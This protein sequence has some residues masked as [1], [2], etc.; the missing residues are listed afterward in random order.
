MKKKER[1][2]KVPRF[3]KGT[4]ETVEYK[5]EKILVIT[6]ALGTTPKTFIKTTGEGWNKE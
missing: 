6:A 5:S 2:L 4:E 3:V 1:N